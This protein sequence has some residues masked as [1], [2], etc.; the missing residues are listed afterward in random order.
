MEEVNF[1]NIF[2]DI[3]TIWSSY[4]TLIHLW[5]PKMPGLATPF[6][7]TD[8]VTSTTTTI[9]MNVSSNIRTGWTGYNIIYSTKY[10]PLT[11]C[12]ELQL[13][14]AGLIKL[15]DYNNFNFTNVPVSY[16]GRYTM[17][18]WINVIT[19]S[20][21]TIGVNFI[22]TNHLSIALVNNSGNL[23]VMCFPQDYL[24]SPIKV[25]GNALL[26]LQ[27]Q[28]PNS[29][30]NQIPSNSG[31]WTFVRCAVSFSQNQFYLNNNSIKNL[32]PE[33][34]Y[35]NIPTDLPFKYFF[36]T[37]SSV[38]LSINNAAL[39]TS[40]FYLNNIYLFNDYLPNNYLYA[41]RE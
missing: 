29:D 3:K 5:D 41:T 23:A 11:L 34:L 2:R 24:I 10:A 39:N 13:N 7:F 21:L 28:T 17:E 19:V 31:I 36:N 8:I 16:V 33:T 14:C 9:N 22:W 15:S 18:F 38:N 30:I 20:Q 25:S 37:G 6:T 32:I 1:I 4:P 12:P 26:T 27:S 40:V 35:Q